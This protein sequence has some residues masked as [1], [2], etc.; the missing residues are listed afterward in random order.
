MG[1]C[2]RL[3]NGA[4]QAGHQLLMHRA[5][6]RGCQRTE[7]VPERPIACLAVWGSKCL[8]VRDVHICLV[9]CANVRSSC[10]SVQTTCK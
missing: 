1:Q 6:Q 3:D 8:K 7:S 10:G 5:Q 4:A 9:K 2:T